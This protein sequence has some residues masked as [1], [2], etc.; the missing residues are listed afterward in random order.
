VTGHVYYANNVLAS[1]TTNEQWCEQKLTQMKGEERSKAAEEN[2]SCHVFWD[3]A[4]R[5]SAVSACL[6]LSVAVYS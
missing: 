4:S 3:W 2:H 1:T 5:L 6:L